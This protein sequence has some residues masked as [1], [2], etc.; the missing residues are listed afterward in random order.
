MPLGAYLS[1]QPAE[2]RAIYEA[3]L[4]H[5]RQLGDDVVVDAVDIGLL[6]KRS[7]TFAE[8]R[9]RREGVVLSLKLSHRLEHPRIAKTIRT[10]SRVAEFINLRSPADVDDEL[11]AWLLESYLNSPL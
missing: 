3:V 1:R 10:G 8:L 9:P 11:R 4:A 5:L 6:I 7:R 2:H